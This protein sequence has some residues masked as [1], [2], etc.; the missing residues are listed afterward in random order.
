MRGGTLAL[1]DI[2]VIGG[3]A[4]SL[5][6]LKEILGSLP[7][8][9]PGSVFVVIHLAQDFPGYLDA[10]LARWSRLRVTHPFDREPFYKGHIYVARPDYHL[11]L[12]RGR[13]RMLRGP[14]ENRHR[15]AIDPLFRT[16]AREYNSR[17]IGLVLSGQDDDGSAGLYAVKQRG[18]VAIVQDPREAAA[19]EMPRRALEYAS[20][21]YILRTEDIAPNLVRLAT[22]D[23]DETVMSK[24]NPNHE[25]P[26]K[27][28]KSV[29]NE[30]PDANLT[31]A[32]F[33]EGEGTPSVFACPECHGTLWEL[34]DKKLV[35]FRCRVGHSYG[36]ESLARELSDSSETALWAAMRALE[37]KAAMQRRLADNLGENRTSKRMRDQSIADEANA[38]VI[39]DIIFRRDVELEPTATE[40]TN[41]KSEEAA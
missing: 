6:P 34:K 20:P 16:A 23:Q 38:R 10:Q 1:G 31:V 9:F 41:A 37:E 36:M 7:A 18:G 21:H 11:T 24:T 32:Y 5:T 14:R 39:R 27:K 4:G 25:G 15:P 40:P 3:S 29:A 13:I 8:D 2:V 26:S 17:V 12:E 28:A 22:G 19:K 30:R 33:D 35:R